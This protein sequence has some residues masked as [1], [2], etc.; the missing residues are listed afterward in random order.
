VVQHVQNQTLTAWR[1]AGIALPDLYVIDRNAVIPEPIADDG[2]PLTP[3]RVK[4][5][6]GDTIRP[7]FEPSPDGDNS[8]AKPTG[9]TYSGKFDSKINEEALGESAVR[10][11]PTGIRVYRPIEATLPTLK[12]DY[13]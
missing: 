1:Q 11:R 4:E 6:F 13:G 9:E 5:L 10:A 12:V 7:M 3:E 8:K 2:K